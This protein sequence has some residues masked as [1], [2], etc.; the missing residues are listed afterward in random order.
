VSQEKLPYEI[1]KTAWLKDGTIMGIAHNN[2]PMYG[3]Q[4]HPESIASQYGYQL[5]NNFFDKTGIKI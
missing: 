4:F 1:R 5:I 2:F 3:V